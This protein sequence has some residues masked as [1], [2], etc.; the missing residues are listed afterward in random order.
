MGDFS[1]E[2]Y[3]MISKWTRKNLQKDLH[4]RFLEDAI[5][6]CAMGKW[7]NNKADLK[8]I[9]IDFLRLNG[10]TKNRAKQSAVP[11]SN[12]VCAEDEDKNEYLIN[13]CSINVRDEM[14]NPIEM[15]LTALRIEG[16]VKQWVMKSYKCKMLRT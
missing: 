15:M 8:Y 6:Y 1:L 9:L 4:D 5:Q 14:I 16:E 10:L 13:S 7:K 12:Y 2:K 11:L 3:K